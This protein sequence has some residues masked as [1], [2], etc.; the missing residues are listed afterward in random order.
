MD[1]VC[2]SMCARAARSTRTW[3]VVDRADYLSA[4]IA[5]VFVTDGSRLHQVQ[6]Q[7]AISPTLGASFSSSSRF[8][9]CLIHPCFRLALRL[10]CS[11]SLLTPAPAPPS[12]SQLLVDT[13]SLLKNDHCC[14]LQTAY[15]CGISRSSRSVH[16][17]RARLIAHRSFRQPCPVYS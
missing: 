11:P 5:L 4:I 16:F 12:T 6:R 7:D 1:N 10:L 2:V 15:A 8:S 9:V 3:L 13:R 14:H 17:I